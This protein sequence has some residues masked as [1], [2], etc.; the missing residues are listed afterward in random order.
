VGSRNL[1]I[2]GQSESKAKLEATWNFS[3]SKVPIFA[4]GFVKSQ[5]ENVTKE[6]LEKIS[7][8]AEGIKPMT[9]RTVLIST[10]K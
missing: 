10:S 9:K 5:I 1:K 3:F 6:A 2:V 7:I 4:R 8:E